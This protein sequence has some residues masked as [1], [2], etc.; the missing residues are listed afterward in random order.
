MFVVPVEV[1]AIIELTSP[2]NIDFIVLLECPFEVFGMGEADGFN[3][4]IVYHKA[5]GDGVPN[6]MPKTGGVL[7]VIVPF[8]VESFFKELVC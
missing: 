1:D 6:M 5:E 7:T 4:K 8:E 2:V 3:A